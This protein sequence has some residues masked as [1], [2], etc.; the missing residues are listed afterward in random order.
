MKCPSCGASHIKVTATRRP[1][2]LS[3][4]RMRKCLIC[5]HPWLTREQQVAGTVSF[6]T[7]PPVIELTEP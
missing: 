4:V 1:D 2:P 6:K 5:S 7:F 3:V